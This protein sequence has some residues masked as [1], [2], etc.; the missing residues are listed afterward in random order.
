MCHVMR[1]KPSFWIHT[2]FIQELAVLQG[3]VAQPVLTKDSVCERKMK[4]SQCGK[5]LPDKN[6]FRLNSRFKAIHTVDKTKD[7]KCG[8]VWQNVSEGINIKTIH[9]RV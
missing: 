1:L 7:I 8:D 2:C 4:M 3:D 9:R 5:F 6:Q